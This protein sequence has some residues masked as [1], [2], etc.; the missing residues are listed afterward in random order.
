MTSKFFMC[1]KKNKKCNS[2]LLMNNMSDFH[3]EKVE[4]Q[5]LFEAWLFIYEVTITK[6]QINR[7]LYFIQIK[8]S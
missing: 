7:T 6:L 3:P 2:A 5:G 8:T 1:C 4:D